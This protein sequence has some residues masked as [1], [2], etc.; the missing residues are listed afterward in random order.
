L[1]KIFNPEIS[2]SN[3]DLTNAERQAVPFS[4][5]MIED[6]AG[7]VYRVFHAEPGKSK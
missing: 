7:S 5:E 4:N 1:D 6:Q 2:I 3:P